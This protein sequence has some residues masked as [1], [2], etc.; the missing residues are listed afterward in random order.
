MA[1]LSGVCD[2]VGMILR[3]EQ[4]WSTYLDGTVKTTV[5]NQLKDLSNKLIKV[6]S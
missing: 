4:S 3:D 1:D 5:K 2:K 6:A